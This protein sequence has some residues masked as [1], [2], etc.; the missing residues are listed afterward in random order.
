MYEEQK[1]GSI[2]LAGS[3]PVH[4]RL[5]FKSRAGKTSFNIA[6]R[7]ATPQETGERQVQ[8]CR[9]HC[10][11]DFGFSPYPFHILATPAKREERENRVWA[12]CEFCCARSTTSVIPW[13]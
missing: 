9:F 3:A 11:G 13:A 2:Q 6:D 10:E 7:K 1:K 12:E 5:N 4:F 8:A